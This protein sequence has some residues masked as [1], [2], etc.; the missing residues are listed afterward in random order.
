MM[1]QNALTGANGDNETHI[2]NSKQLSLAFYDEKKQ[3]IPISN[4]MSKFEFIIPRDLSFSATNTSMD[5]E[6]VNASFMDMS[7]KN[8][9][10]PNAINTT[11]A[12]VSFHLQISPIDPNTGYVVLLKLGQTPVLN[13]TMQSYDYWKIFCPQGNYNCINKLNNLITLMNQHSQI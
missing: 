1:L 4:A 5:F 10:L 11:G 8:H 7:E 6:F 2:G 9:F 3:E 13:S 12:N